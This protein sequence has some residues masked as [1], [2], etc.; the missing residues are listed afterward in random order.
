MWFQYFDLQS[1]ARLQHRLTRGRLSPFRACF[2]RDPEASGHSLAQEKEISCSKVCN[3]KK[4]VPGITDDYTRKVQ[5]RGHRPEERHCLRSSGIDNR[6]VRD[7][8]VLKRDTDMRELR[9]RYRNPSCRFGWIDVEDHRP[10]TP[11]SS[12]ALLTT[13]PRSPAP[14]VT[15]ALPPSLRCLSAR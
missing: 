1:S 14:P 11:C 7:I 10:C 3:K 9:A 12:R 2:L 15:M 8:D 4:T 5:Q 6:L 13:N